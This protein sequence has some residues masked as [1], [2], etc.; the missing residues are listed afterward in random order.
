MQAQRYPLRAQWPP[1]LHAILTS[2]SPVYLAGRAR[3][4]RGDSV[5]LPSNRL[6]FKHRNDERQATGGKKQANCVI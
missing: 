2:F 1:Y 4:R 5:A 6:H 3:V